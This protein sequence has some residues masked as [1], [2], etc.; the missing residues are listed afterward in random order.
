MIFVLIF[1]EVALNECGE[2]RLI[3][4]DAFIDLLLLIPL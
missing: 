4:C 1:K 2:L 3:H